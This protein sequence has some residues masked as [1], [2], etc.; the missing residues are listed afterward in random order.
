MSFL[1]KRIAEKRIWKRIFIERLTEPFHLNCIAFFVFIFGSFRQKV[2]FDLVLRPY[3]A[4]AILKA[5]IRFWL[6]S[7]SS[8]HPRCN[9][10]RKFIFPIV[11]IMPQT[12][13][14]F[15]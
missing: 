9:M 5:L 1:L 10:Q 11:Q 13:L 6:Q 15:P 14:D 12:Y 8:K 4:F 2:A 3:H 7:Q